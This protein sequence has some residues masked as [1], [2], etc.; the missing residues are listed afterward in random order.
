MNKSLIIA[1]ILLVVVITGGVLEF[2]LVGKEYK[3]FEKQ[4]EVYKQ[5]AFDKTITNENVID[6]KKQWIKLR[7]LSELFL[8]HIDTYELNLRITDCTAFVELK[9]YKNAYNQLS[10]IAMLAEYIP[11]LAV[12]D[13]QHVI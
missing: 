2:V 4:V 9:D 1:L 7:E 6:M 13:I 10:I 12:P 3:K 11:N 5:K 8:P